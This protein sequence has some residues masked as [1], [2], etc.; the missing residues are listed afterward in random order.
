MHQSSNVLDLAI[1]RAWPAELRQQPLD[2]L[3]QNAA[4]IAPMNNGQ[5]L[6]GWITLP[7]KSNGKSYNQSE[8]NYLG[9]LAD[10]SLIGLER[11]NVM[12][13]L[14]SRVAEL[15]LLG[16]FSQALN[17]TI[18]PDIL[19]ELVFTNYQRLLK[20]DNFFIT[21]QDLATH[22]HYMAFYVENGE[23][24]NEKEGKRQRVE[25][26][27]VSQVWATGQQVEQTDENGRLWW[28]APLNAGATGEATVPLMAARPA[29][30]FDRQPTPLRRHRFLQLF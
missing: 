23:R 30:H 28:Y 19:M 22:R 4:V 5:E 9:N 27:I 7:N 25:D 26:E 8:L 29:V 21:L 24:L 3:A 14:E 1:Q 6:L 18:D 17:Y 2:I 20:I 10:Q 11:A 15:D 16:E 12:R 13:R